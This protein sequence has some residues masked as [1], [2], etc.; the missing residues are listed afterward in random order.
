MQKYVDERTRLEKQAHECDPPGGAATPPLGK[1]PSVVVN[2]A[3]FE[4]SLF[5]ASRR[6]VA[7]TLMGN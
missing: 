6:F 3:P 1:N 7:E 2:A 5:P 4:W